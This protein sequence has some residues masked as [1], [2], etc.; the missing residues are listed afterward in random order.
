VG[1]CCGFDP[2]LLELRVMSTRVRQLVV[3]VCA[4][5]I[6]NV[7]VSFDNNDGLYLIFKYIRNFKRIII[8]LGEHTLSLGICRNDSL[9]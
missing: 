9:V 7:V 2:H 8:T 1:V 6:E 3:G 4:R 5:F